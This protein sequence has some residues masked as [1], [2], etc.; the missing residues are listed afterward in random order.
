MCVNSHPMFILRRKSGVH[1]GSPIRHA[2]FRRSLTSTAQFSHYSRFGENSFD[3]SKLKA[4]ISGN[5]Y[6]EFHDSMNESRSMSKKAADEVAEA[7][8]VWAMGKG[9][10][11]FAHWAS[12]VRGPQ[13]LLKH[14]AF[15]DLDFGGTMLPIV[16]F[17]SSRLFLSE[18]DG[19]SFPNGGLRQT[20]TAAAFLSWDKMSPPFL[21]GDTL[22]LP[23]AFVSWKGDALDE[24]T[25]LLRSMEAINKSGTR[26]LHLLGETEAKGVVCNVGWEQEFFLVNKED[27][28]ARPDLMA[29]GRSLI[30]TPPSRGQQTDQNYFSRLPPRVKAVLEDVQEELHG[31][32]VPLMVYHAEV[33]PGQFEFSPIFSMTNSAADTNVLS[34]DVLQEVANRHDM[35]ALFH[36]KPFAGLNGSGKHSNW[37]L[38]VKGT[39]RNLFVAG[40]TALHQKQ[41]IA[42]VACM[43]RALHVHG[44]VIRTSVA[45]AGNDH[46]LGAQEAPPAIISLYL[47]EIL[48]NHIQKI[49][50]GG[51][52]EG[53]NA[54]AKTIDFGSSFI[55]PIKV[56]AEDRNRTAP[57][58]FCGNRFEFRA[59]GS[60][61]HIAFPLACVQAAVSESFDILS[62]EIEKTGSV[63]GAVRAMMKDHVVAMFNGDGYSEEWQ[64]VEAPKRGLHNM[65]TSVTAIQ[66]LDSD[67][68]KKLFSGTKVFSEEELH[69]RKEIMLEKFTQSI[70]IEANTL[71]DM[72]LTGVLPACAEDLNTFGSS[73]LL[74]ERAELY[75]DIRLK[76]KDLAADID[77]FPHNDEIHIQGE[78]AQNVIRTAM[79]E[80][81]IDV[82]QAERFVDRKLWP[83]PSYHDMLFRFQTDAE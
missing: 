1:F 68:N 7:L 39:N 40:K 78:Y 83:F 82:D 11:S 18:T 38:N 17:S 21:K 25:P 56:A 24:K 79:K 13:N 57:F 74:G 3:D 72:I 73:N 48:G 77:K 19:S 31:T 65:R 51:P 15:L 49:I 6:K 26:L 37:G 36:E 60:E 44:D 4:R 47:G 2:L 34:M 20:H 42:M 69:A 61:Q 27:F 14:D 28:L 58:P 23:S 81:R 10:V 66:T 70:L 80:I 30:G 45:S 41:F 62:T 35:V 43:L 9:A 64:D 71:L 76:A 53:Y 50:D 12:P 54:E 29:C 8:R 55:E 52:L 32:G 5:A 33:A 75:H 16:K 59:V 63:E 46:R 22:Y 67:K